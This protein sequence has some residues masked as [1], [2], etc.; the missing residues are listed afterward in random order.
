LNNR[1]I[2]SAKRKSN[3]QRGWRSCS[4]TPRPGIEDVDAKYKMHLYQYNQNIIRI[5]CFENN[6]N[7]EKCGCTK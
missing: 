6:K 4:Q 2:F 5:F 3:S 7:I 1:P